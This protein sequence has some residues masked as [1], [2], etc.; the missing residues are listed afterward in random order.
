MDNQ[1]IS[2]N[3]TIENSIQLSSGSEYLP[4]KKASMP[5]LPLTL[6]IGGLLGILIVLAM[7]LFYWHTPLLAEGRPNLAPGHIV[8]SVVILFSVL[9]L[10]GAMARGN[11]PGIEVP[12][13]WASLEGV[14]ILVS[15]LLAVLFLLVF[16]FAPVTFNH[17]SL[18]DGPV[19][20][21]SAILLFL[22]CFIFFSMFVRY[23]KSST[24]P[25]SGKWVCL[26]FAIGFFVMAM[27]EVS[28]FQRV[29]AI[30]TPAMFG[31]NLQNELNLHNFATNVIENL[32]YGGAFAFTVL[33]PCIAFVFPRFMSNQTIRIFLPRPFVAVVGAIACAYNYDMWNIFHIQVGFFSAL[34]V[35]VYFAVL[36]KQAVARY[37]FW[38]VAILVALSQT[39]FL[40]YGKS[41]DRL[42]NV[43]EYKEFFIPLAFYFYSLSICR[44][45]K[46]PEFCAS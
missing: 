35:L 23:R 4:L 40:V 45:L 8:R 16:I 3:I 24:L 37:I 6:F 34:A 46:K 7:D 14:S 32:Y 25:L 10:F 9:S 26:V 33:L 5:T 22:S 36:S 27:E 20:W 41:F 1:T 11:N 31:T 28:W 43:T 21:G 39:A 2:G 38:A 12:V 42:W 29:F 17:A 13:D 19:E 30:E 18:E 44:N 15:F